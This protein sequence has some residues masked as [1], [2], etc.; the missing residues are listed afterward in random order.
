[1]HKGTAQIP[2]KI[3]CKPLLRTLYVS[4]TCFLKSSYGAEWL[5][6]RP[7]SSNGILRC[8]INRRLVRDPTQKTHSTEQRDNPL[9]WLVTREQRRQFRSKVYIMST[10]LQYPH[11]SFDADGTA[12]I[13]R[14]RYKVV[15]LAGE[16]YHYERLQIETV[17]RKPG[18]LSSPATGTRG[19]H[20]FPSSAWECRPGRSA[21]PPPRRRKTTQSV[22]DGIPTRSMGT[23]SPI[24]F[25]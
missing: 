13:E 8:I 23:R 15:H 24:L 25:N 22:E 10:V 14:T 2:E 11:L 12:R 6:T 18:R 4:V 16:H 17:A 3:Y 5:P 21:A 20:S 1:M 9:P 7:V 19:R